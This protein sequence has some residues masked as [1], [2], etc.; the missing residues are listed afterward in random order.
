[1]TKWG[2]KK[3]R[4]NCLL[5]YPTPPPAGL[6][7]LQ[8]A[9]VCCF[10]SFWSHCLACRILVP[11]PGIKP[12]SLKWKYRILT[13]VVQE[14]EGPP[15]WGS[16]PLLHHKQQYD[17]RE[18]ASALVLAFLLY[19]EAFLRSLRMNN[20]V[21]VGGW[22]CW[23]QKRVDSWSQPQNKASAFLSVPLPTPS[24]HKSPSDLAP[25]HALLVSF[26]LTLPTSLLKPLMPQIPEYR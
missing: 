13:T 4:Q 24:H 1:M 5:S 9:V 22:C 3:Q 2:W 10:V 21:M 26:P 12:V 11:G 17:P 15:W 7:H 8:A 6:A 25:V 23:I 14:K 20:R 19:R 16:G 18:G